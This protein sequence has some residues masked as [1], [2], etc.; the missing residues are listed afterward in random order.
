MDHKGIGIGHCRDKAR[1]PAGDT[2]IFI[3]KLK[4]SEGGLGLIFEDLK[5]TNS[6]FIKKSNFE[7]LL[8]KNICFST[9]IRKVLIVAASFVFKNF[10]K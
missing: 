9:K 2:N 8:L 1:R 5:T 10:N 7:T 3:Q 4:I 6:Q